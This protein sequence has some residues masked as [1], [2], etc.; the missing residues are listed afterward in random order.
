MKYAG[1]CCI[2]FTIGLNIHRISP[3]NNALE[4]MVRKQTDF[5][6]LADSLDSGSKFEINRL[7]PNISSFI[8]NTPLAFTNTIIKPHIFEARSPFLLMAALE[9]LVI[10]VLAVLSIIF[11]KT[12]NTTAPGINSNLLLFC[13]S[14]VLILYILI[15][16]ATPVMGAIVRYKAPG[17][18]FLLII[19]LLIID[20]NKLIKKL[21]FLKFLK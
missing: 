2:L 8:K 15:G 11:M 19:F 18:P 14:F 20:K 12:R 7:K 17:L 4:M 21:P 3:G 13:A 16:L 9:N 10:F 6:N 1:V 5:I